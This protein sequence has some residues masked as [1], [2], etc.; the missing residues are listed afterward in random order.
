MHTKQFIL[1]NSI[2]QKIFRRSLKEILYHA[3]VLDLLGLDNSAKIQMHVGGVY[4]D[5]RKSINRFVS[6][7]QKLEE[8]IKQRL[9]IENDSSRYNLKDCIQIHELTDIPVLF[10]SLH[11]EIYNS[12]ETFTEVFELFT[13]TWRKKD[14]LPMVDYSSQQRG[15]KKGRHAETLDSKH[16]KNFLSL[17]SHVNYDLMLEIKNKEQSALKAIEIAK[18]IKN[19]NV[20]RV[21][22][23]NGYD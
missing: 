19:K 10:D 6:R 15:K 21:L 17:T 23:V 9:V 7:F 2:D 4:G 12:G 5:K 22:D 3:E 11:H 14:G 16:F 1:I 8:K 13:E 20:V 18:K